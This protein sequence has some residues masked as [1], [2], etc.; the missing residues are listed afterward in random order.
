MRTVHVN[1]EKGFSGGEVQQFHLMQALRA[2]G[3]E[4]MLLAR[5]GGRAAEAGRA[6]GF[7][8]VELPMAS[9]L[10][11]RGILALRAALRRLRPDVVHMHTSRAHALAVFALLGLGCRARVATRR[12]DYPLRRNPYTRFLYG[13]GLDR[14]VAI[15]EA[16]RAELLALGVPAA[17]IRLI[18]SGIDL[19]RFRPLAEASAEARL[20]ARARLGVAPGERVVGSAASLHPR[21]GQDVLI[22]AAARLATPPLLLLAGTGPA[23][24]GL[25]ALAARL[26]VQARV[27]FLGQVE[28]VEPLLAALDLFCLPSRKEGLGVAALEAMAAGLPVVASAVGGLAESVL[29]EE[30]GLLV[31]PDD[32]EALARAL[33][34]LLA[35]AGLRERM[36]RAG[37]ARVGERYGAAAMA[38]ANRA[39]YCELLSQGAGRYLP[40]PTPEAP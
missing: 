30:T 38:A 15:S 16:V 35:D 11:L 3:D 4:C 23:R 21:K 9:A 6:A 7:P 33:E 18:P 37:G 19:E 25:E 1:G 24:A 32:P 29:P 26:G 14:V 20:E 17:R 8:T 13:A 34:R 27:R 2:A 10:D 31:P 36:G 39:L 40:G 22:R 12:M 5:R 28:P